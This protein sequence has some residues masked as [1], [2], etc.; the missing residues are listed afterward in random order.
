[1]N[2]G[3]SG[4][5][6]RTRCSAL[7]P[8]GLQ[9]P[10]SWVWLMNL[11]RTTGSDAWQP[12][13]ARRGRHRWHLRSPVDEWDEPA[14]TPP[15]GATPHPARTRVPGPRGAGGYLG[16]PTGSGRQNT[17]P[18]ASGC[19]TL[20]SGVSA[21]TTVSSESAHTDTSGR[22]W[23]CVSGSCAPAR[24]HLQPDGSGSAQTSLGHAAGCFFHTGAATPDTRPSPAGRCCPAAQSDARAGRADS[25]GALSACAADRPA[26]PG[27]VAVAPTPASVACPCSLS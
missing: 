16:P 10:G 20:R 21:A 15:A 23:S 18:V 8:E 6:H 3:G 24:Q 19:H 2:L 14:A 1:M 9:H 5:H 17:G 7:T 13:A 11:P 25:Y 27:S 4:S 26:A 12:S 22:A